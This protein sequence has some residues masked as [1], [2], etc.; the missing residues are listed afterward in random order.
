MN[1]IVNLELVLEKELELERQGFRRTRRWIGDASRDTDPRWYQTKVNQVSK[2]RHSIGLT[3]QVV[4]N[5]S[6]QGSLRLSLTRFLSLPNYRRQP[7]KNEA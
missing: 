6:S 5:K 1:P 7:A 4:E 2:S 3:N